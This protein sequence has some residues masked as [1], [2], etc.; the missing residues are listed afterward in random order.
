MRYGTLPGPFAPTVEDLVVGKV[1]ELF[2]RTRLPEA[3]GDAP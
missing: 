3:A 1:K 2:E